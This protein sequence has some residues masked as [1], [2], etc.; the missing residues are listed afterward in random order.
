MPDQLDRIVLPPSLLD[1]DDRSF[2]SMAQT[3]PTH[4]EIWMLGE[5]EEEEEEGRATGGKR[6]CPGQ[7]IQGEEVR[8]RKHRVPYL[9]RRRFG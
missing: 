3:T 2:V 1:A 7:C 8:K 5:G 6:D 9:L 4:R